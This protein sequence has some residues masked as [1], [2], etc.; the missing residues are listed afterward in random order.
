MNSN[1]WQGTLCLAGL[2][3][4]LSLAPAPTQARKPKPAPATESARV[5]A[6]DVPAVPAPSAP[7]PAASADDPL[8]APLL[9][10]SDYGFGTH[11]VMRRLPNAA[12]I[13]DLRFVD[14][15][16]QLV[17]AL[18]AWPATYAEIC[19]EMKAQSEGALKGV[20]GYTEDKVVATDFRGESCTSVFDAEAGIA[21]D[22]TFVKSDLCFLT[23]L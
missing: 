18:P 3:L 20:L 21:L 13:E 7:V 9:L 10:D 23:C 12:D 8:C 11:V 22:K 19:A 4:L 16:R 2:T 5:A 6:A 1:R 17:I 15:F 14:G